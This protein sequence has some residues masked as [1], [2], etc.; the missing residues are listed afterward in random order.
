MIAQDFTSWIPEVIGDGECMVRE[1]FDI[2]NLTVDMYGR[3]M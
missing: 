1:G 3:V 2:Y